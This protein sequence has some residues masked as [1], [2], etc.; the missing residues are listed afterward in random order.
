MRVQGMWE[1][2]ALCASHMARFPSRRSTCPKPT[3]GLRIE[4]HERHRRLLWRD[5]MPRT[6][7]NFSIRDQDGTY[8]LEFQDDEG[9]TTEILVS[10]EQLDQIVEEITDLLDADEEDELDADENDDD[11]DT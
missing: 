1:A 7:S 6:L 10:Y 8:L 5:I 4:R 3:P 9:A 2:E 11:D